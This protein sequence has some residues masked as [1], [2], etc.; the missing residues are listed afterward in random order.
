MSPRY[1]SKCWKMA[2]VLHNLNRLTRISRCTNWVWKAIFLV[3]P[4]LEIS[5]KDCK[6]LLLLHQREVVLFCES[7]VHKTTA[8]H[9]INYIWNNER[10]A[11]KLNG[12]N[13][14]NMSLAEYQLM[15]RTENIRRHCLAWLYPHKSFWFMHIYMDM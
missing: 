9:R 2:K 8:G 12:D 6:G 1:I 14:S 4:T 3:F 7:I 11:Q 13:R 10:A 15:T 5:E